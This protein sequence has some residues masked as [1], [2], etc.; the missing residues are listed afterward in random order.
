MLSIVALSFLP[1]NYFQKQ[2]YE[3]NIYLLFTP[4]QP[5]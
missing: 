5:V 4:L 1:G 3:K 2:C